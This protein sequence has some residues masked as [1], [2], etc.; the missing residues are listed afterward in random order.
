MRTPHRALFASTLLALASLSCGS[1]ADGGAQRERATNVLLLVVD[2]LRADRLGCYGYERRTSPHI[3]ALA[4]RGMLYENCY[5]QACWTVPSMISMM[6]GVSVTVEE[7]T[8]PEFA[9]VAETLRERGLETA[10]FLAN[11][12]LFAERGFERGF[13]VF[14]RC[15]NV[16]GPTLAG[17]FEAWYGSRQPR[18]KPFFA[19]VQFIDPH[20]PYA[21]APEFDVFSG[22]RARQAELVERWRARLPHVAERSPELEPISFEESVERMVS[23]SNRYDG[24]VLAA[25]AGI[26]RILA[27]LEAGGDLADTLV[28]VCSDHG[29]MLYEQ[30]TPPYLEEERVGREGGL[31]EGVKDLFGSGHRLWY[32]EELWNTPMILAGPGIPVGR[33]QA[34]C[35]NLD[36]YPTILEA[37]DQGAPDWLE[38]TSLWGGAEPSRQE[39]FAHGHMTSAVREASGLKLIRYGRGWYMLEGEGPHPVQLFDTVRDPFEDRDLAD[40][41]ALDAHRLEAAILDWRLEHARAANTETTKAMQEDL[42]ALGYLD[43]PPDPPAK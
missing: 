5:S 23:E 26:G 20:H 39:V 14:E 12:T 33:S 32:F 43:G 41:R 18:S 42:R 2:T 34:L 21:P 9:V 22:P 30:R 16:D 40:S 37:L 31:P 11:D 36:V 8:L 38:G 7:T 35:A 27:A 1:C 10:A 28:I 29:E 24:E 15:S 3:D 25:D 19:W 17:R 13:D 6:T 4:E